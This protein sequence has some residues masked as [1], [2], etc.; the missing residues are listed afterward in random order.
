MA[1]PE[2]Q[3]TEVADVYDN[4]M[5]VVPYAW[6]VD[7]VL[8]LWDEYH[9]EPRR[10]LDLACG[11]GN[12]L[13]ELKRRGFVV[14]G[15]DYSAAMLRVAGRKVPSG[16]PLWC[17]DFRTLEI[18]SPPF[19]AVVCLFDSLNYLLRLSD[20]QKAFRGVYR[21]LVPGGVFVFDMNAIRAL[22]TGM[23]DQKG[24]GKDASLKYEW[25]SA[26]EP[27]TRLCTI[28]ME[29]RATTPSGI[30]VFHETHVQKGYTYEEVTTSLRDAGFEVL[31][32]K[33]A[34]TMNPPS[35]KTDRFY[36]VAQRM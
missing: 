8:D 16:T 21:H 28:Q 1:E 26:W 9:F 25:H 22:D 6:W 7:Y 29:F 30:R 18:P 4:L 11:T 3:F 5:S 32:L 17:Q 24:I 34:F 10:V 13:L 19:D 20:L 36:A 12:V 2:T 33:E 31:A 15:A 23:F 14:E 27:A 35:P